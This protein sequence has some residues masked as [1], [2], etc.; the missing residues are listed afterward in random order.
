[1]K[2]LFKS[3]FFE[4]LT[5]KSGNFGV[6]SAL[7]LPIVIAVAG[8]AVDMVGMMNAR[9]KM[10]DAS[11]AGALAAVAALSEK[12]AS[13]EE[14]KQIALRFL[15]GHAQ[16]GF[17]F[18][19]GAAIVLDSTKSGTETIYK[20]TIR[21]TYSYPLTPMTGFLGIMKSDIGTKSTAMTGERVVTQLP[22]SF[23]LVL[24]RSGSMSRETSDGV[25]KLDALKDS[26]AAMGK[27]FAKIDPDMTFIRTGAS[28]FSNIPVP[29][30][31][32]NWGSA[33]VVSYADSFEPNGLTDPRDALETAIASLNS[34]EEPKAHATKNGGIPK[35]VI[36]YMTDGQNWLHDEQTKAEQT[37]IDNEVLAR[38][39][40]AK[41]S[42]IEVYTIGFDINAHTKKFLTDCSSGK[43]HFYFPE[44]AKGLIE[45]FQTIG[46]MA[47]S[48]II[49]R[50]SD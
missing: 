3:K 31:K 12:N 6:I 35:K 1:M 19:K 37:W 8:I 2:K 48:A 46:K 11:D 49:P 43:D 4:V 16:G 34:K 33:D 38:C 27:T 7:L 44:G 24:D 41:N 10:R 26:V 28:A 17:D 14:A 30:K 39:K 18:S 45:N 22:L 25:V 9:A 5:N 29:P 42:G 20:I 13:E 40:A 36:L 15:K 21:T 50:I 47:S 23:Y 32:M